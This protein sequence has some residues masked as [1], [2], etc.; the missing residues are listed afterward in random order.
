MVSNVDEISDRVRIFLR[1]SVGSKPQFGRDAFLH[2][3]EMHTAFSMQQHVDD[4]DLRGLVSTLES[5][6][7][8]L[9]VED[10]SQRFALRT[11]R[12][13]TRSTAPCSR[14]I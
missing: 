14:S 12:W 4:K 6:E 3:E 9:V 10:A 5:L 8:A 7:A 13:S 1:Q 2:V 11:R